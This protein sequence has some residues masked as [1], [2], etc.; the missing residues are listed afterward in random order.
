MKKSK[1]MQIILIVGSIL[2]IVG[3]SLM[4]WMLATEDD[5]NVIR[6]QIDEGESKPVKFEALT[7]VP[8]DECEYSVKLV[9][10]GTNKFDLKFDFVETGDG[11]LKNYARVKIIVRDN[12]V[13]DDLLVNTLEN[14]NIL[15]S[16][17]FG[18][19]KNTEFQIVYYLPIDVGNEAK[20]AEALFGLMLTASIE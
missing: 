16:V 3:V 6:V 12:V 1:L 15:L 5:R 10:G 14:K 13:Y 18:E 19:D 8:G 2:I 20:N 9:K 11:T 17:D 7:M 4:T